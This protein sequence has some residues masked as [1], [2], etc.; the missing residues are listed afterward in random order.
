MERARRTLF[1]PEEPVALKSGMRRLIEES[2]EEGQRAVRDAS[3]LAELLW[4]EWAERLGAA[5]MDYERFLEIS[6]GYA[7]EIRLWIMGE[8]PWDHC[9]AGLAGRVWRRMPERAAVAGGGL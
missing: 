8:R 9:V 6:R 3:F 2:P 5:G 4:E 7:E 1:L